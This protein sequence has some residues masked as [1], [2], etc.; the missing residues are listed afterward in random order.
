[1]FEV[2]WDF[3]MKSCFPQIL[4]QLSAIETMFKKHEKKRLFNMT[5]CTSK[6]FHPTTVS[7]VYQF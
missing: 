1:M 6:H 7:Y 5:H 3:T 2:S 4:Y